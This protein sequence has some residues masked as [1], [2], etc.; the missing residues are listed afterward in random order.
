LDEVEFDRRVDLDG[1]AVLVVV[2]EYS[3]GLGDR[4]REVR[5]L[6]WLLW[7]ENAGEAERWCP[8]EANRGTELKSKVAWVMSWG[9][10]GIMF[11]YDWPIVVSNGG[12]WD[13]E[14][15]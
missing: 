1:A 6:C 10:G 12:Y 7:C 4:D 9:V 13:A 5:L 3:V 15:S 2:I 8:L 11:A 14:F